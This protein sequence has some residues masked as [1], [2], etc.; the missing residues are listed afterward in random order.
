MSFLLCWFHENGKNPLQISFMVHFWPRYLEQRY[1]T[2]TKTHC[3]ACSPFHK[4]FCCLLHRFVYCLEKV[5]VFARIIVSHCRCC[6]GT[7]VVSFGCYLHVS[8]SNIKGVSFHR[9]ESKYIFKV[10]KLM[11]H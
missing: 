5:S 6:C 4:I 8:P 11:N 3:H 9:I 7:S 1:P 2:T 10:E